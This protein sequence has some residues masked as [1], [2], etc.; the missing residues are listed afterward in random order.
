MGRGGKTHDR[1][2]R[3]RSELGEATR[4]EDVGG[5][6]IA[7]RGESVGAGGSHGGSSSR[8]VV[9]HGWAR[10]CYSWSGL[11]SSSGGGGGGGGSALLLPPKT[12]SAIYSTTIHDTYN[13]LQ[14]QMLLLHLTRS[15]QKGKPENK[16]L[17]AERLPFSAHHLFRAAK[18]PQQPN[19]Q[20]T[21][22]FFSS[23]PDLL[24]FFCQH[25]T[26]LRNG[27]NIHR[28]CY[29]LFPTKLVP[30]R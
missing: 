9:R 6:D 26:Q 7:E 5:E 13:S 30:R 2:C 27:K 19:N 21:L 16:T 12:S 3:V 22:H 24:L 28:N 4:V 29:S 15:P 18:F 10:C 1:V 14:I 8:S 20:T 17:K 23:A 25:S 11:G